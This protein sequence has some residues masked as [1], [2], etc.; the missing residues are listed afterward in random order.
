MSLLTEQNIAP[1]PQIP[2]QPFKPLRLKLVLSKLGE[3]DA[4]VDVNVDVDVN[5]LSLIRPRPCLRLRPRL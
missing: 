1:N 5:E 2:Q 4:L 3:V